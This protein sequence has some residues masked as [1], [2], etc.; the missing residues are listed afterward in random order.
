MTKL[1]KDVER[2]TNTEIRDRGKTRPL[3][4]TLKVGSG[5]YGDYME[6]RPKGTAVVYTV[7]MK[8]I[9]SFGQQKAIKAMGY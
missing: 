8:E 6:L 2:L 9:W 5:K 1:T 4:V 7:T 3:V